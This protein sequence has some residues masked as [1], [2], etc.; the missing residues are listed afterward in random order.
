MSSNNP[1]AT[2]ATDAENE[3]EN[4]QEIEY[5]RHL[6]LSRAFPE[7]FRNDVMMP[8]EEHPET[9]SGT[10]EMSHREWQEAID[11]VRNFGPI[12]LSDANAEQIQFRE[13][14]SP[15]TVRKWTRT[16]AGTTRR[17]I[18]LYKVEDR[19]EEGDD[20]SSNPQLLRLH[21]RKNWDVERWLICVPQCKV[22]DAI[23]SCHIAVNHKK[24]A[25][26]RD[27]LYSR[28]Y[29]ITETQ[30]QEFV[31]TCP[32]CTNNK[33]KK[34]TVSNDRFKITFDPGA[35][36]YTMVIKN[37]SQSTKEQLENIVNNLLD[38]LEPDS[39]RGNEGECLNPVISFKHFVRVICQKM[40]NMYAKLHQIVL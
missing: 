1:S 9:A 27:E 8:V 22:F 33:Q 18:Q 11:I 36:K 15:A 29:N 20:N 5:H 40:K 2:T 7:L 39:N 24:R 3:T 28:Y 6:F 19:P 16:S 35:G 4:E 38:E 12:H 17:L 14:L 26:T 21:K 31:N 23:R 37:L 10:F 13:N 32:V 34:K 25:L 30:I